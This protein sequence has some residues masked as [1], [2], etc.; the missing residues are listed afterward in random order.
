MRLIWML[1]AVSATKQLT[2]LQCY[3]CHQLVMTQHLNNRLVKKCAKALL[4]N[5]CEAYHRALKD[6]TIYFWRSFCILKKKTLILYLYYEKMMI[7]DAGNMCVCV[8]VYMYVRVCLFVG[9]RLYTL[10]YHDIY[11]MNSLVLVFALWIE[12]RSS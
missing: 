2:L 7:L 3:K 8:C 11:G 5:R 12:L 10:L 6:T 9:D 1:T 4:I